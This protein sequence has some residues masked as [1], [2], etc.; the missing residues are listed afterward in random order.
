MKDE[1]PLIELNQKEVVRVAFKKKI[2]V[3]TGIFICLII[4]IAIS[5]KLLAFME[6]LYFEK[7]KSFLAKTEEI[8]DEKLF[9]KN[10]EDAIISFKTAFLLNTINVFNPSLSRGKICYF[11]GNAYLLNDENDLA[12]KCFKTTKTFFS[13]NETYTT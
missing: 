9:K 1:S 11:L 3:R 12:E 7:A 10:L 4:V 5:L 6:T 13:G 8:A 2:L